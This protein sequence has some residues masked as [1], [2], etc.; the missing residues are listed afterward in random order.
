MK[1][2][3]DRIIGPEGEW[4]DGDDSEKPE[5]VDENGLSEREEFAF[6]C[7]NAAVNLYGVVTL[8]E[9]AAIYNHY[10]A[11]HGSP[12]SDPMDENKLLDI[13]DVLQQ[14]ELDDTWFSVWFDD[15]SGGLMYC[16]L[17]FRDKKTGITKLW[18][19]D[20]L[21]VDSSFGWALNDFIVKDCKVWENEHP[22]R[23]RFD[24]RNL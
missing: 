6:R 17:R 18:Y 9:M 1:N 19:T 11:G 23:E 20:A 4:I 3:F 8:A 13:A 2:P 10:A 22:Y 7:M 24:Y 15:K 21:E 14:K 12:V 16:V 5:V